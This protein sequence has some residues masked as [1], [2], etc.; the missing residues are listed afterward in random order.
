MAPKETKKDKERR[1]K[2]A[3]ELAA[4]DADALTDGPTDDDEPDE[5]LL[6]NAEGGLLKPKAGRHPVCVP[7][8]RTPHYWESVF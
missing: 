7:G 2:K 4:T 5:E 3:E 1:L 8:G 6:Y